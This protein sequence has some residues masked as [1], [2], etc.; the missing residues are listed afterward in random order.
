MHAYTRP[1]L[2]A[3]ARYIHQLFFREIPCSN[4]WDRAGFCSRG[5]QGRCDGIGV[6]AEN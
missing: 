5:T 1:L 2:E 3:K 4:G 6:S